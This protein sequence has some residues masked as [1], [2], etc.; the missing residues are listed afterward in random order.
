MLFR[1]LSAARSET[2]TRWC[3]GVSTSSPSLPTYC[4]HVLTRLHRWLQWVAVWSGPLYASWHMTHPPPCTLPCT[5]WCHG[6]PVLA[7]IPPA[8]RG[9]LQRSEDGGGQQGRRGNHNSGNREP[10][11]SRWQSVRMGGSDNKG[12]GLASQPRRYRVPG[13][14]LLNRHQVGGVSRSPDGLFAQQ[15]QEP[16]RGRP[17]VRRKRTYGG[18]PEQRV[19]EQ[20]TWA[21]RTRSASSYQRTHR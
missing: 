13:Q 20:G 1:V 7:Y 4:S 5:D 15:E 19:E 11:W 9:I 17:T 14:P 3:N 18:R 16:I 10:E 12:D 6:F 2:F 21:S 8:R